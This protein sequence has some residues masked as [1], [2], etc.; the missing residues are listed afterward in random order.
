MAGKN[1][2]KTAPVSYKVTVRGL[3]QRRHVDQ[4]KK[5]LVDVEKSSYHIDS[6]DSLSYA[7][8]QRQLTLN[9]Q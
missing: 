4:L 8:L 5:R 1:I 3:F 7:L 9:N 2:A 6:S